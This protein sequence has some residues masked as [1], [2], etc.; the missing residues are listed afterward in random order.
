MQFSFDFQYDQRHRLE[1][2]RMRDQEE[3]ELKKAGNKRWREIAEVHYRERLLDLERKERETEMAGR[4]QLELNRQKIKA[5]AKRCL[6]RY[7]IMLVS[8]I[9]F[10]FL[11]V[12]DYAMDIA[13]GT[14]P[15]VVSALVLQC[16]AMRIH[17]HVQKLNVP[18][19]VFVF[20]CL[21]LVSMRI[22][23]DNNAGHC[24]GHEYVDVD[25]CVW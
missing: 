11:S 6:S 22:T 24:D 10:R 20:L 2:L 12:W 7:V 4:K 21:R 19:P 18:L 8:E 5:A 9:L 17:L 23:S 3:R 25:A 16:A 1:I 13:F 14:C 15:R